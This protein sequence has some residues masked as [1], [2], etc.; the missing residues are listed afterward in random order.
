MTNTEPNITVYGAPWCP[1]CKRA[2]QFLGEQRVMFKWVDIDDDPAGREYVQQINNGKQIIPTIVFEDGSLLVEPSNAELAAKLNINPKAERSYYNLIVIGGGPAG[3]TSAL[4]AARE[5][6]DTLIIERS[7]VGGQTGVTERIDN[8]P[9]FLEGIAGAQLADQMRAHAERFGVEILPAQSVTNVKAM[10]DFKIITTETGDEYCADAVIIA[11]GSRYRRLNLPGEEDLI[12]AGIHFCATCD[13]P[14]YKDREMLVV[15]G[16]NSGVEE[17]LFLAKFATKVTI[18][19]FMD[20][21]GASRRLQDKAAENPK[22]E[23]RTSTAVQEFRGQN[24]LESV[25]I[26]DMESGETEEIHPAAAFIFIGLD[27]NT[28]FLGDSIE[29]DQWN[30]IKTG[31]NFSTNIP[32]VYAAGDV[33]AGST[34]QVTGAVGEGST[35]AMMV[36]HYMER[37][38]SS[39]GYRGD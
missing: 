25:L 38:Q 20:R 24:R 7:G 16:G 2:K 6:M 3:L 29:L 13:G 17:G 23:I 14:F 28:S 9:G 39:R 27:P 26:K 5:G 22:I 37:L 12:G 11:T 1:D 18:V 8:Y 15:G 36:R 4:Y 19:E 33:R 21:L 10:G 35:A 34:K 30:F 32:G 31:E